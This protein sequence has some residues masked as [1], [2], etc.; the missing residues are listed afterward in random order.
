MIQQK[1]VSTL[2]WPMSCNRHMNS[3]VMVNARDGQQSMASNSNY[4]TNRSDERRATICTILSF[5]DYPPNYDDALVNSKPI[6]YVYLPAEDSSS[7]SQKTRQQNDNSC[8]KHKLSLISNDNV[9][10]D[11]L[12]AFNIAENSVAQ[13]PQ[14]QNYRKVS[15]C[16]LNADQLMLLNSAPPKYADLF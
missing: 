7:S 9:K 12:Q 5:V 10:L 6:S 11:S 1:K 4:R 16:Q 13:G 8:K 14:N 3:L 2:V 15:F